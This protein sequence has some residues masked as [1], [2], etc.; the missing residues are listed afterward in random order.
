M[1]NFLLFGHFLSE[2][3]IQVLSDNADTDFMEAKSRKH[4]RKREIKTF[5]FRQAYFV[6]AGTLLFILNIYFS[7]SDFPR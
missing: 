2:D 6:L 1:G 3:Q 4:R 5:L 7:F